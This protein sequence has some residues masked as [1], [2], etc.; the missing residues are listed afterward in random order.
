[1]NKMKTPY[2]ILE[3]GTGYMDGWYF[4]PFKEVKEIAKGWDELRPDYPHRIITAKE[5]FSMRPPVIT[6]ADA[7]FGKLNTQAK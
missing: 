7:Y 6:L 4:I 5:K 3:L 2:A 1:M